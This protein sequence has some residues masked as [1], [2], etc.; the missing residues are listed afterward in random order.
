MIF[1]TWL[2]LFTPIQKEQILE[3]MLSAFLPQERVSEEELVHYYHKKVIPRL[4]EGHE[5]Y[6]AYD[7][8]KMIAYAIYQKWDADSYYLAEMAVA[9]GYQGQGIGK[10]LVFSILEKE[11]SVKRILLVTESK[12]R[13]SQAFYKKI[14]FQPSSFRH[15]DYDPDEFIGFEYVIND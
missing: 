5:T 13:W 2:L 7:K 3:V 6:V 9:S 11:P 4:D 12:N 1:F 10:K 8:D 14:G 15:P